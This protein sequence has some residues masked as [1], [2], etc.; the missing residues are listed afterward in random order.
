MPRFVVLTHNHPFEHWDFMLEAG[1]TLRTWRLLQPADADGPVE[2]EPLP[3][4]R[5][6]YL[7]YE[8]PVSRDRG[9][10]RR[11]D[12][13]QYTILSDLPDRIEVRLHGRKLDGVYVLE[14]ANA[15]ENRW[16]FSQKSTRPATRGG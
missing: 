6:D 9:E 7:N 12:R 13:G 3:D 8:G 5:I 16:T 14:V 4:H 15:A 2:A 10:V 1:R 11:W